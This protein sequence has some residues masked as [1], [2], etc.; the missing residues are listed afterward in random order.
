MARNEPRFNA[1][2]TF[3]ALVTALAVLLIAAA[4]AIVSHQVMQARQKAAESD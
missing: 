2:W 3:V 4:G 1:R